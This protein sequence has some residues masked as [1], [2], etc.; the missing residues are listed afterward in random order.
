MGP[1]TSS[2]SCDRSNVMFDDTL[3]SARKIRQE[4]KTNDD[5][6]NAFDGISY[7]KGGGDL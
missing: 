7:Q 1:T 6:V 4:I 2:A 5:I 3:V